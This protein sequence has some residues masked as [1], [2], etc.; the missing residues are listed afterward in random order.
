MILG[1]LGRSALVVI[2]LGSCA[3]CGSAKRAL[4]HEEDYGKVFPWP[5]GQERVMVQAMPKTTLAN[6]CTMFGSYQDV[7]VDPMTTFFITDEL[8]KKFAYTPAKSPMRRLAAVDTIEIRWRDPDAVEEEDSSASVRSDEDEDEDEDEE[9][10]DEE[11]E[12]DDEEEEEEE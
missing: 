10:E 9:E 7:E 8:G 5:K 3:A 1:V 12:E 2:L 6:S 11:D 4:V